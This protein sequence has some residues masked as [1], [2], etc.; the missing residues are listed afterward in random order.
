MSDAICKNQKDFVVGALRG[1]IRVDGRAL[2]QIRQAE[3][4]FGIKTG[5]CEVALGKTRALA[6]VSCE[7]VEPRI[8]KPNDGFLTFHTELSPMAEFAYSNAPRGGNEVCVVFGVRSHGSPGEIL[9][10]PARIFC[11]AVFHRKS[12]WNVLHTRKTSFVE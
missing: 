9:P 2:N 1:G 5:Q 7:V 3:V 10:S 4:H 12:T 11:G 8:Q 6:V